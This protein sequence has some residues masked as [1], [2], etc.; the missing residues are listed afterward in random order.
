MAD[1]IGP[2]SRLPG[3]KEK[4]PSGFTCDCCDAP[5]TTRITGETD[6]FGSEMHDF[7]DACYEKDKERER[8]AREEDPD[9]GKYICDRCH[10]EKQCTPRR[11][12]EEGMS[13]PVYYYCGECTQIIVEREREEARRY[14]E[15]RDYD[16]DNYE[17]EWWIDEPSDAAEDEEHG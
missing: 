1:V 5:A 13:G 4:S 16:D 17:D 6:S 15:H 8:K 9:Y 7:C 11:D 10:G 3:H 12:Y 14:D 2:S